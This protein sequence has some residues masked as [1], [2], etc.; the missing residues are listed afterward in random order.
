MPANLKQV[1]DWLLKE[2]SKK[3]RKLKRLRAAFDRGDP[4]A[5][6]KDKIPGGLQKQ[7]EEDLTKFFDKKSHRR[8]Y[9]KG[10]N[11]VVQTWRLLVYICQLEG[12]CRGRGFPKRTSV[13]PP[14]PWKP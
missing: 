12:G 10:F 8:R 1:N 5:Y 14:T 13:Q 11:A 9:A 3:N 6:I 2:D 4:V 7:A